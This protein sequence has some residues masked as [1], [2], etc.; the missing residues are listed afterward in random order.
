M[1]PPPVAMPT[2]RHEDSVVREDNV[3]AAR[4]ATAVRGMKTP[5]KGAA[6]GASGGGAG[7]AA[8]EEGEGEAEGVGLNESTTSSVATPTLA[9]PPRRATLLPIGFDGTIAAVA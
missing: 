2:L 3:A 8:A 1:V 4:F 7:E 6:E 9:S 5:L